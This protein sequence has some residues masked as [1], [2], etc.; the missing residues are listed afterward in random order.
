MTG[1]NLPGAASED[2][3]DEAGGTSCSAGGV[4]FSLAR[5]VIAPRA[6]WQARHMAADFREGMGART[7]WAM[8]RLARHPDERGYA[9]GHLDDEHHTT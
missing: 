7:A 2:L 3:P 4:R 8:A 6:T 9:M 5:W 1:L